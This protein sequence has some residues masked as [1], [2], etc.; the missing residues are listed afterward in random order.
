MP[1]TFI[2]DIHGWSD[3]LERVL[4]RIDG[5]MVFMGDLIDRG[6]DAPGVLKHV[7]NLCRTGRARCLMGNH[8]YTLLRSLGYPG[9]DF[10]P[11]P[12][13]FDAWVSGFG[14]YAV[15]DAFGAQTAAE[16]S[17]AMQEYL[18]WMVELP[19]VLEGDEAERHWVAV[20]AGLSE[21]PYAQQLTLLRA[22]WAGDDGGARPLFNK[23]WA[24]VVPH[25][26]PAHWCVVSGHT[27]VKTPFVTNNRILCDTSGG[28]DDRQLSGVIFPS[29]Q[30]ITS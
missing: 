9:S 4:T 29:G 22:G 10:S 2:G 8:E 7:M 24:R 11:D 15:M 26:L 20:H 27:P 19:W 14:G 17:D 1:V 13:L 6:P 25:D 21:K 23:S 12:R 28:L 18:P 16:L 30:L 3:R 5:D